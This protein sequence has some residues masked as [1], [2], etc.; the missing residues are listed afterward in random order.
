VQSADELRKEKKK[1]CSPRL[2]R[3]KKEKKEVYILIL[4]DGEL[5]A[6]EGRF[7][8]SHIRR[9]ER[10]K[11]EGKEIY[12]RREQKAG[13]QLSTSKIRGNTSIFKIP[14]PFPRGKEKKGIV[15]GGEKL[16]II[17][18]E[19]GKKINWPSRRH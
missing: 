3:R 10:K 1:S 11:R 18:R 17:G 14:S 2:H 16:V 9:E 6:G 19:R 5:S 8:S 13:R 15:L 4:L 12:L 7:S